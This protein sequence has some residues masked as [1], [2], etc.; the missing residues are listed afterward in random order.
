MLIRNEKESRQCF[1]NLINQWGGCIE[2]IKITNSRKNG[3][4]TK[5]K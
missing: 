4:A 2:T 3:R 5:K 1:G